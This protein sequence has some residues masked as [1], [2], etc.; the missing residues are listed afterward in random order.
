VLPVYATS[1]VH[2]TPDQMANFELNGVVFVDMPWMLVADHPA[3]LS[4]TRPD[5][6]GQSAMEFQR[7]YAVG[8]D[9]YR[10]AQDLLKPQPDYAPLDGVTGYI[11]PG[12][13]RRFLRELI[14]AQFVQGEPKVLIEPRPR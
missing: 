11:T 8:I 7:F 9:A 10:L 6:A 13:D 5:A 2:T 1:L 4:Y 12:P 14:P 3:V